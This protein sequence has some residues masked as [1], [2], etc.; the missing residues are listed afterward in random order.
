MD[1]GSLRKL[2][3]QEIIYNAQ[4]WALFKNLR[5]KTSEIMKVLKASHIESIVHGSIARGDINDKSDIDIFI[6]SQVSSFTIET[7]L[8]KAD[9]QVIGRSVV[10]AT[11][12]YAMKAYIEINEITKISFPLM[13]MR[14]IEQELYRF[15]GSVSD[16]D[17]KMDLRV[18]GVDKRL[19][20][21]VPTSVGH[22]E[23]TILRQEGQ[24]AKLLGISVR[25]VM[26]RVRALLR[27]QE[28]GR[29]G[30]YI[31]RRLSDDETFERVLKELA[32][33]HAAIR[34]RL[35]KA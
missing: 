32:Y 14:T 12:N 20:L 7:T 27:R 4:H 13:K 15:G 19:M 5:Q 18:P 35:K 28:V 9:I 24:T 8:E 22:G 29:T 16:D 17:L 6:P 33:E 30:V 11:P 1:H 3:Y 26:D 10:Q 2:E 25:T 23:S 34:R 31:E 21:I